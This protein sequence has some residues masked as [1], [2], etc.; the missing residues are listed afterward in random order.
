MSPPYLYLHERAHGFV[1]AIRKVK[2]KHVSYTK[3]I[4]REREK[5]DG[6]KLKKEEDHFKDSVL[7]TKTLDPLKHLTH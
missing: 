4:E 2:L 1:G 7:A 3:E 6:R 5:Q